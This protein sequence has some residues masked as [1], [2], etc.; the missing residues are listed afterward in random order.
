MKSGIYINVCG[1]WKSKATHINVKLF[2]TTEDIKHSPI[3]PP[4]T[5][6]NRF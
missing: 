4:K 2:A 3:F 6:E 1:V 5:Y